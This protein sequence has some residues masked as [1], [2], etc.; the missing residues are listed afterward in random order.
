MPGVHPRWLWRLVRSFSQRLHPHR[1]LLSVR[2]L[3]AIESICWPTSIAIRP[4]RRQPDLLLQ[5]DR[6]LKAD[7]AASSQ[8]FLSCSS[9]S[10]AIERPPL[11]SSFL[12]TFKMSHAAQGL[13]PHA[14]RS[15]ALALASG[16]PFMVSDPRSDQRE[17]SLT[18]T[19]E[20]AT[21]HL[22]SSGRTR[23]AN[24]ELSSC[25]PPR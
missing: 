15:S 16:W 22:S 14:R 10:P 3:L 20:N 17:C 1:T 2:D 25:C 13:H 7:R 8:W 4:P 6:Q 23:S 5:A 11:T 12:L 19:I 18:A 21:F 9:S 24:S